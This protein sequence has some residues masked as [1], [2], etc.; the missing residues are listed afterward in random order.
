MVRFLSPPDLQQVFVV[1]L[2]CLLEAT[3]RMIFPSFK[4]VTLMALP[5]A[6]AISQSTT[7]TTSDDRKPTKSRD[8]GPLVTSWSGATASVLVNGTLST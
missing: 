1:L 3:D 4:R 5:A 8:M 6:A 2:L 7:Q